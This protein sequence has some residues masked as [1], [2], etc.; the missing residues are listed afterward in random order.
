MSGEVLSQNEIDALLSAISTGE[1]DAEEL[2]KEE[3]EKKVKVYDFK[4]AL[5][6]SKDQIRSLTRIHDNFARLL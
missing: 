4:R 1:M 6:F 3:K 2:K 5:R